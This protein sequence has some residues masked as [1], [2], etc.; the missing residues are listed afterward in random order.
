MADK[1]GECLGFDHSGEMPPESNNVLFVRSEANEVFWTPCIPCSRLW[2]ILRVLPELGG[3]IGYELGQ[4]RAKASGL[5][6]VLE[7]DVAS[8]RQRVR[9]SQ[10]C[11]L[12]D[13][14]VVD[15]GPPAP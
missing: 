2:A 11:H 12:C 13:R 3:S 14:F 6:D 7:R 15:Y 5:S 10:G 8:Q 4:P 9:A 1:F